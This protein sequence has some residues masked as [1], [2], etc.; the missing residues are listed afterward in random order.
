M[1]Y[2][3]GGPQEELNEI[4][5]EREETGE[6]ETGGSASVKSE[7]TIWEDISRNTTG[8]IDIDFLID[9]P[10]CIDWEIFLL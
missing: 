6:M 8:R 3:P 7:Y 5:G 9:D 4:S 10:T 1:K 2:S